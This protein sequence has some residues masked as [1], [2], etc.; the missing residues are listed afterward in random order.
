MVGHHD[1]MG[2][3]DDEASKSWNASHPSRGP[4]WGTS[5]AQVQRARM[6]DVPIFIGVRGTP[7]LVMLSR[8]CY[9]SPKTVTLVCHPRC[10]TSRALHN[11]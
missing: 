1:R 7:R 4:E 8:H 6:S 10:D 11:G 2:L 3:R 5:A 9:R